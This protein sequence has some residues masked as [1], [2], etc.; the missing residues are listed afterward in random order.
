MVLGAALGSG[1]ARSKVSPRAP[2]PGASG[3][4]AAF[5]ALPAPPAQK[6]IVTPASGV[7]G[8]IAKVNESSRFVVVN[9]AGGQMPA[10]GEVLPVYRHGLKVAEVRMSGP[11]L[12]DNL[13]GDVVAGEA[14]LGDDVRQN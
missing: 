1:C 11:Q 3:G 8:R 2:K 9:F 7:V 10:V 12:E 13:V 4:A 5:S 14:Q 6:L